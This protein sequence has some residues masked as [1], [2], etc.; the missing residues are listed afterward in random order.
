LYKIS[1]KQWIYISS[2]LDVVA[3]ECIV[4]AAEEAM[5]GNDS[6]T[7]IVVAVEENV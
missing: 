3:I 1:R 7:D 5:E 2:F 4:L 6:S